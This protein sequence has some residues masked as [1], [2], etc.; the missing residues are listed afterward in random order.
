MFCFIENFHAKN[1]KD[2]ETDGK[3]QKKPSNDGKYFHKSFKDSFE[4]NHYL[5]VML[6]NALAQQNSSEEKC[7]SED[8]VD[9]EKIIDIRVTS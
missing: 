9:D 8:S 2:E 7:S 5:R 6:R 3:Q 1:A 4:F